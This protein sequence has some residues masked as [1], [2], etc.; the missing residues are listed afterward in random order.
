MPIAVTCP[1]CAA[2]MKAPDATAGKKIKC[3]KCQGAITVPMPLDE[4]AFE[5][6]ENE[7]AKK[8]PQ[9]A[10]KPKVKADVEVDD[11]EDEK[12]KKKPVKAVVEEDEDERDEKPRKKRKATAVEDDD[13]DEDEEKPKKKKKKQA[14]GGTALARNIVGGVVLV[15]LLGVVGFVYYDKFGKKDDE[16]A[17]S[18]S[19]GNQTAGPSGGGT[20]EGTGRPSGGGTL[21]V[22]GGRENPYTGEGF[23]GAVAEQEAEISRVYEVNAFD[24]SPQWYMS[25]KKETPEGRPTFSARVFFRPDQQSKLA[26][27]WPDQQI[28][29][30][31]RKVAKPGVGMLGI[32]ICDFYAAEV[33]SSGPAPKFVEMT[34]DQLL[35]EFRDNRAAAEKKW[36]RPVGGPDPPWIKLTGVFDG[37][38]PDVGGFQL[39]TVQLKGDGPDGA[40]PNRLLID[41]PGVIKPLVKNLKKGDRI[42]VR[43]RML[44]TADQSAEQV[45]FLSG[46]FPLP[47]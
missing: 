25:L 15:I 42:T 17:S 22:G 31:G 18:S 2:K 44:A 46:V 37:P 24:A 16:T 32:E 34:V 6:V 36:T 29:I 41:T 10:A 13:D 9:P 33:I 11:E 43:V 27:L 30:R 23:V 20:G 5:V 7:P 40:K 8:P 47:K 28:K 38:G 12:P 1:G 35:K 19:S 45:R 3:P 39:E 4:P 21:V 26:E 14:E